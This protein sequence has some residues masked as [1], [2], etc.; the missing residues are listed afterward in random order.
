[1]GEVNTEN[2]SVLMSVY[3][4]EKPEYL[5]EAMDSMW[6]QTVPTNDFVLVCDGPLGQGLENVISEM[7]RQHP[8][9]LHI[10]RLKENSGL[11]NALNVGLQCCKNELIA[12][13]DSDDIAYN[14][15]CERQLKV[16]REHPEIS[17]CSGTVIEFIDSTDN[18]VGKRELPV[19]HEKIIEYSQKRNPCNHPSVVFKKTAA[20]AAGSYIEKFHL[21]EDY[22]LWIRMLMNGVKAMNIKEPILYM[23]AP[24]DMYMRRG[25]KAYAEDMLAFHQWMKAERWTNTCIYLTGAIPHAIICVL[26]NSIRR[27]IY[28]VIHS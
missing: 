24:T 12:R 20:E 26:P 5:R 18:V 3:Y 11:G 9:D 8:T 7:E 10:V 17:L 2:Y 13:M 15:R 19:T 16:F 23:R 21:F 28:K 6:N 4:K 27:F 1:M 22:H 25:G 14:D